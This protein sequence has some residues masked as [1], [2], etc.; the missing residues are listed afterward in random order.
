MTYIHSKLYHTPSPTVAGK[1][2]DAI[3]PSYYKQGIETIDYINSK[4]MS[5]LE[6]NV[7]KYVSRYKNKNGLE[8]LLKCQWYINKLIELEKENKLTRVY[9]SSRKINGGDSKQ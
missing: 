4:Q 6:G 5:Y 1:K 7:V 2:E 9:N 3:N 8:D